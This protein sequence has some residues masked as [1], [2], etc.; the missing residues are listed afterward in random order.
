MVCALEV[1]KLAGFAR[2]IQNEFFIL[3]KSICFCGGQISYYLVAFCVYNIHTFIAFV[4]LVG[5]PGAR[6]GVQCPVE[7]TCLWTR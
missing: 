1:K 4:A 5:L 3:S 7:N 6:H 2:R